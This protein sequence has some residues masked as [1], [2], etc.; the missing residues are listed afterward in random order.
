MQNLWGDEFI[1]PE[2]K[3]KVDEVLEKIKN[4]EQIDKDEL[5]K[6]ARSK[7]IDIKDKLEVINKYT[8]QLLGEHIKDTL[9][10]KSKE[11]LVRYV[12]KVIQDGILAYDTETNNSLDA[13]TGEIIGLCLYSPSNQPAYVPIKHID[14]LTRELRPNQVSVED[15][16]EQLQRIVDNKVYVIMHNGKFDYKFTKTNYNVEMP[17]D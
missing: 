4:P 2:T 7:K 9:V 3:S 10:I 8:K 1:V 11:Q 12:D 13:W 17:I 14:Y 6:I 15:C 5:K 16:K